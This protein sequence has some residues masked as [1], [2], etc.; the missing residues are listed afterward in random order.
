MITNPPTPPV[1]SKEEK[2]A[3]SKRSLVVALCLIGFVVLVFAITVIR[4][5]GGTVVERM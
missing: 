2:A 4:M 1:L 5:Q 3:Q